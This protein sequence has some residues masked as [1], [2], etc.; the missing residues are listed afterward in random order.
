MT[1]CEVSKKFSLCQPTIIKILNQYH[2]KRYTKSQLFSPNINEDYFETIDTEAKAYFLGLIITDGCI[3]SAKGRSPLLAISLQEQD[4]Y[5]LERLKAELNINKK[6]TFD[7]RGCAEL[8]V[9][10]KKMVADLRK[11]GIKER[12]SLCTIL[13]QNIPSEF[14]QH[15]IRGILDGDGSIS[16]YAR[17]N[18]SCHVK[19]IR[20]CQGNKKFLEDII[21]W[22]YEECGA[23]KINT[24]QEKD[25]LWSIAYRKNDS[26]IKI[27]NYLYSDATIYLERK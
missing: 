6:I 22:L 20:F 18:R 24:Y 25:S 11:Y 17:P 8:Q 16:F 12:K 9:Y 10:S 23:E 27:I 2:I 1:L 21:E 13:P 4:L 7:G 19:A 3:H 15:L 5:I 14:H 26:V